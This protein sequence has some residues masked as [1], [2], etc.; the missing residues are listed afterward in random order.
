MNRFSILIINHFRSHSSQD[1]LMS[2]C[3]VNRKSPLK[4]QA[5]QGYREQLKIH[6]RLKIYGKEMSKVNEVILRN[7][8]EMT[9]VEL[10]KI[11]SKISKKFGIRTDRA[12]WR[13]K[14]GLKAWFCENW[15]KIAN[16][17]IFIVNNFDN[18]EEIERIRES[19]LHKFSLY[20]HNLTNSQYLNEDLMSNKGI[21]FN[22]NQRLSMA[23]FSGNDDYDEIPNCEMFQQFKKKRDQDIGNYAKNITTKKKIKSKK[24]ALAHNSDYIGESELSNLESMN[25]ND[26]PLL[27]AKKDEHV[28][29]EDLT[30]FHV[31]ND[32]NSKI[33]MKDVNNNKIADCGNFLQSN[34]QIIE[35]NI[36]NC[37]FQNYRHQMYDRVISATERTIFGAQDSPYLEHISHNYLAPLNDWKFKSVDDFVKDFLT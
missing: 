26:K 21:G 16:E 18:I 19:N 32:L 37:E 17:V 8:H 23:I 35:T 12:S 15:E 10:K 29:G 14:I 25:Y 11:Q 22:N 31:L 3:K 13:T 33:S 36:L 7:G 6:K 27:Y 2:S 9:L 24:S 5:T 28:F 30:N 20:N 4:S 34:F 1:F